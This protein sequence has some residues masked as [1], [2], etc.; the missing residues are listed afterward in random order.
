VDVP[1]GWKSDPQSAGVIDFNDPHS[2]RFI[3][4]V[5][6][7]ESP[8]P[9]VPSFVSAENAF[10]ADHQN[11]QRIAIKQ[12]PYL[13]HQAADWVF[14]YEH[15]GATRHVVYR[16]FIVGDKTYGIYISAPD[17]LFRATIPAFNKAARTFS[18]G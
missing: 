16:S 5:S 17:H 3:R 9:L 10:K 18:V 2:D 4:F 8:G 1:T 6:G 7:V 12:V 11:Y 13:G 14:T 15:S